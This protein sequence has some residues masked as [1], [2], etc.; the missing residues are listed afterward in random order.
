MDRRKPLLVNEGE[1]EA[2]QILEGATAQF[3]ASVSQKVRVADVLEIGGSGLTDAEYRYALQAHFDFVV[4]SGERDIALFAVEFDEAHHDFDPDTIVRDAM[5]DSIC[6]RFNFPLLRIEADFLRRGPDH[7]ALLD[8]L[9]TLWFIYDAFRS[10]D[11]VTDFW[12]ISAFHGESNRLISPAAEAKG[13]IFDHLSALY[14]PQ[15]PNPDRTETVRF[16]MPGGVSHDDPDG[17]GRSRAYVTLYL[18]GG[19]AIVGT[20]TCRAIKFPPITGGAV[21]GELAIVDAASRLDRFVAGD[22]AEAWEPAA[23]EQL[24][25]QTIGWDFVPLFWPGITV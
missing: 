10:H 13:R 22:T 19:K 9:T 25:Q 7:G 20:A 3:E 12:A 17:T 18:P 16:V 6:D 2:R 8:W 4:T 11:L 5:K 15:K 14:V 24:R 23:V 21:A 1:A